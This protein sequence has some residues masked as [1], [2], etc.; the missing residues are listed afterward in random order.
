VRII[1]CCLLGLLLVLAP[2]FARDEKG[3]GKVPDVLNFKMK[4]LDG[5]EVDLAKFQGKVVLIVNVASEC[6]YTPQYKGLQE[7]YDKYGK[8]GFVI[9]GVPANEFGGQE[10][11]SDEEIG[12]FCKSKYGVTFPMTSKVVVKGA[13]I[14][15]LYQYLTSKDTNPKFAGD[16]K[17]N[18]TKFLVGKDGQVIER[19]EPKVEPKDIAPAVE[20]ELKK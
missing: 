17:W 20:G 2:A 19:F 13:G 1:G 11:G 4:A 10:P 8:D 5:K 6:G 3:D 16:V 18:F 12:K 15:P 7:L 14:C 9:L